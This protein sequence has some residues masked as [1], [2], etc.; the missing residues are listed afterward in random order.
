MH[1]KDWTILFVHYLL[2]LKRNTTSTLLPHTQATKHKLPSTVQVLERFRKKN[3]LLRGTKKFD[4][5]SYG[6]QLDQTISSTDE[7]R[8]CAC[9][10]KSPS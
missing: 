7:I 6:Q 5:P 10:G 1:V 4:R 3:Y 2:V 9:R 8:C